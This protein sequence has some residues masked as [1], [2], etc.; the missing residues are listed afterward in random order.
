MET[1]CSRAFSTPHSLKSHIKTHLKAQEREN[2]A[3]EGEK[4]GDG[5]KDGEDEAGAGGEEDARKGE[6]KEEEKENKC[7]FEGNTFIANS[8]NLSWDDFEPGGSS[9]EGKLGLEE[10]DEIGSGVLCNR[11]FLRRTG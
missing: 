2:S 9:A 4:K 5:R 3:K 6:E 1:H 10:N 8:I 7:D 11:E